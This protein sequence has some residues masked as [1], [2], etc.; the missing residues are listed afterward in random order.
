[1]YIYSKWEIVRFWIYIS[2]SSSPYPTELKSGLQILS[3]YFILSQTISILSSN[4]PISFFIISI[5]VF[6]GPPHP[7]LIHQQNNTVYLLITTFGGH[8]STCPNQHNMCSLIFSSIGITINFPHIF[9]IYISAS[10]IL[11]I[12]IYFVTQHFV[13]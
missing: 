8:G 3:F 10:P 1:M 4:F 7:F 5:L 13:P 6:L 9:N 11:S 2:P 12:C